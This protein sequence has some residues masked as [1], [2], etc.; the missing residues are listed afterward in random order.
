MTL[1]KSHDY[2]VFTFNFCII[3]NL[4]SAGAGK[5]VKSRTAVAGFSK[6]SYSDD[7]CRSPTCFKIMIVQK[8]EVNCEH[9]ALP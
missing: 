3:Y 9:L 1:L 8:A 4:L 5:V 6:R 7:Y 2:N